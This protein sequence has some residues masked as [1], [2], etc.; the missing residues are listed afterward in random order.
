MVF[1]GFRFCR[2]ADGNGQPIVIVYHGKTRA[3]DMAALKITG[4]VGGNLESLVQ[5]AS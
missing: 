3:D 5:L 4:D 1:S 2:A